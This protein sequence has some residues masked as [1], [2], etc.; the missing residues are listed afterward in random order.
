MSSENWGVPLI[1]CG[2]SVNNPSSLWKFV[3][4]ISSIVIRKWSDHAKGD[5]VIYCQALEAGKNKKQARQKFQSTLDCIMIEYQSFEI[6][7]KFDSIPSNTKL[8]ILSYF[9]TLFY[10]SWLDYLFTKFIITLVHLCPILKV[11]STFLNISLP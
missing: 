9:I 11:S 1:A 2:R 8:S 7:S 3:A 10:F 5:M 6:L 4:P